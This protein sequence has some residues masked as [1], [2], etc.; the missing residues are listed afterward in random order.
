MGG[1]AGRLRIHVWG[2]R[3]WLF[4]VKFCLRCIPCPPLAR[5]QGPLLRAGETYNMYIMLCPPPKRLPSIYSR[6]FADTALANRS[7]LTVTRY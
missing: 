4:L 1:E 5:P 2:R 7:P 3:E 6:V